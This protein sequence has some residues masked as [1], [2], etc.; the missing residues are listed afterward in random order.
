P[1]F[2]AQDFLG[3]LSGYDPYTHFARHFER[4]GTRDPLA[5]LQYV[6]LKMYLCDDILVKVDRA[7]MAHALEVR[8][9][10]LD[11]EVVQL[12]AR[13]PSSLKLKDRETKIALRAAASKLLPESVLTRK[14]MGFTIPLPEWFRSGLRERAESAFFDD[15][16]GASGLLDGAGLR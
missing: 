12:A 11:Q 16:G 13:M 3:G 15:H 9:P 10:L 14:K 8:V 4:A 6:D 5:R 2:L 1:R 7:S